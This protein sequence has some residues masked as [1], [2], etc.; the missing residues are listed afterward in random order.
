MDDSAI[1]KL[2]FDRSQS[3]LGE[4]ESKYGALCVKVSQNILGD[5]SDVEECLNDAYLAVW[6]TIP[7]QKP[8]SLCAYIC[9]VVR[10]L[11]LKRYHQNT[12]KKRASEYDVALDELCGCLCA[13]GSVED[14]YDAKEAVVCVNEFLRSESRTNRYIFVRRYFFADPVSDIAARVSMS[15]NAV[16]VRLSRT[17]EKLRAYLFKKGVLL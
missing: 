5:P 2:L 16:S 15:E 4:I 1:I 12:A 11:S 13:Q 9:A 14:E 10:N 6:N 8:E 7:P 3:A 17:R